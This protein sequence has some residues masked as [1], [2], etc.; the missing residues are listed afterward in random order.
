MSGESIQCPHRCSITSMCGKCENA[1]AGWIFSLWPVGTLAT[2]CIDFL[3]GSQLLKQ[4]GFCLI[5]LPPFFFLSSHLVIHIFLLS[6]VFCSLKASIPFSPSVVFVSL[7]LHLFFAPSLCSV[8]SFSFCVSFP[9]CR[10][11]SLSLSL[12]HSLSH[13]LSP[14]LSLSRA[15]CFSSSAAGRCQT[16]R[17]VNLH[18]NTEFAITLCTASR[19]C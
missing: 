11:F 7:S 14:S 10:C 1:H 16:N 8:L 13:S 15:L 9:F 17:T 18:C 12:S 19:Y 3:R 2:V 5:Y 4:E 6:F